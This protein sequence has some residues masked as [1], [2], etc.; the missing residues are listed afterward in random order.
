[1]CAY[2][3]EPRESKPT[4]FKACCKQAALFVS[5]VLIVIPIAVFAVSLF[6]GG[7]LADAEGWAFKD[8]FY[9]VT[10]NLVGL[11][12]PLT[13]VA[14][15]STTG[16]VIILIVAV[17]SISIAGTA[18]GV[19]ANLTFVQNTMKQ[20]EK[21]TGVSTHQ[22][23]DALDNLSSDDKH[24]TFGEFC[25]VFD[26]AVELQTLETIF[27]EMD[28][29]QSG[30]ISTKEVE[31]AKQRIDDIVGRASSSTPSS[32][33]AFGTHGSELLR[34]VNTMESDVAAIKND[35]ASILAGLRSGMPQTFVNPIVNPIGVNPMNPI[36]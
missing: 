32:S 26:G 24:L 23:E 17:W 15:E 3:C 35:V 27:S 20:L 22:L 34:R 19:I 30:C 33:A 28:S 2:C 12:N 29:D 14:P 5:V 9:Y 6:F 4:R 16:E 36:A 21:G 25:E 11:A 18:I 8:G 13:N 7:I 10:G 1:V 31:S